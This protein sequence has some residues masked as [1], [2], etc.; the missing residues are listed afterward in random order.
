MRLLL[1]ILS[2]SALC[3]TTF[4]QG[5]VNFANTPSTLVS[6]ATEQNRT[7]LISGPA[8]S[9]YFGLL[10]SASG[11]EGTF[12]F[13]GVYA[14][15][16]AIAPGRF[17]NNGAVVPGWAVGAPLW[18]RVIGWHSSLGSK[19]N[20]GWLALPARVALSQKA[21]GTA[22][23]TDSR[24]RPFPPLPLFDGMGIGSG[25]WFAPIPDI[26]VS[27]HDGVLG[28]RR[29]QFGFNITGLEGIPLVIEGCT[30]LSTRSWV[31][32]QTCTL[33]NGLLY[34]SDPQWTNYPE[35]FYRIRLP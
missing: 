19:F 4:G 23:G 14:T 13:A 22:G 29:N 30:N 11:S 24:G 17:V 33:T 34:F 21:L 8:G 3:I 27:T 16:S 15:N 25:F 20:P 35:R 7:G 2:L 18:Y 26:Q 31:P 28:V 10:T 12:S 9:W 32:L 6:Y 5:I 1:P